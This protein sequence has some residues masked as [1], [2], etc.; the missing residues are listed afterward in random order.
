MA[1][2]PLKTATKSGIRQGT[3]PA[4]RKTHGKPASKARES[5]PR[6]AA[7][8]APV[9]QQPYHHGD[10][11]QALL[12][13]AER[14]LERDGIRGLTLRAVAREAG[15]SHAAPTHHFGDLARLLSELAAIGFRRFTEAL[16]EASANKPFPE[17][18]RARAKA[19]IGFAQASPAMFKLMFRRERLDMGCPV[20]NEAQSCAFVL[21]ATAVGERR[22]EQVEK[23]HLTL[24]Q[25]ADIAR[26]WSLVHGFA[27]LAID[28]R[29]N[30]ILHGLP[31]GTTIDMLLDA[32]LDAVLAG[33]T[34]SS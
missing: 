28:G 24:P 23:E 9:R 33:R 18:S 19:Y 11:H 15:V 21:M 2:K 8:A 32:M 30:E 25:A 1:T 13:T 5:K 31:D 7:V 17:A 29:L 6:V 20:L 26:V 27:T 10:L 4:D 22:N 34:C 16:V 14:I 3:A 12:A